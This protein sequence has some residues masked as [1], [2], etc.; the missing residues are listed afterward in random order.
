MSDK[1]LSME[2]LVASMPP[3]FRGKLN[4][5]ILNTL[6]SCISD[7]SAADVFRE[8]LIGYSQ[9]LTKGNFRMDQY[10]N[11]VKYV[12]YKMMGDANVVAFS[13][14]FPE[15]MQNYMDQG[16]TDKDISAFVSIFH[17]SKLVTLIL[18]QAMI[19]AYIANADIY[20]KAI[21][22]QA[23]LMVSA[24]SDKVRSDA[25][26]S[27]L[28]HLKPPEDTKIELD[29]NVT[30]GSMLDELRA[31]T[32]KLAATQRQSIRNGE[33]SARDVAHSRIVEGSCKDVTNE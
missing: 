11:A 28:T 3:Q 9:V 25:A 18:G 27:L 26:N 7:P 10:V 33:L 13:K 1:E 30:G 17:S 15:K 32:R 6:N 14:T 8:N 22:V 2:L 24:K 19:P 4:E 16:K 21:N 12:S 29:L 31:T 23:E 5:D 20:Q